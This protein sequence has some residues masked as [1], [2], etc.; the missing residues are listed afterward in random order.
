MCF[1][2]PSTQLKAL[3][4]GNVLILA[5]TA[6]LLLVNSGILYSQPSAVGK[7]EVRLRSYL[8]NETRLLRSRFDN[9]DNGLRT[10]VG[11]LLDELSRP[12]SRSIGNVVPVYQETSLT[13]DHVQ[14]IS[15]KKP[16]VMLKLMQSTKNDMQ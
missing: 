11:L 3:I 12:L 4:A 7:I 16:F 9:Q 14:Q 1:S 13:F 15:A 10:Q 2:N 8:E 6:I 5:L